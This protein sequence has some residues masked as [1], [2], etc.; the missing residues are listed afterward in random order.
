MKK[1]ILI[2]P[3]SF[4]RFM[5][6][7]GVI[8]NQYD[9]EI[10]LN[11][12]GKT[13]TEEQMTELCSDIDKIIV[14]ID[15]LGEKVLRRAGKLKAISKYGAGLDNIDLQVA[16]ELKIKVAKAAGANAT[17]VAELGVGLFFALARKIADAVAEVK[18]GAWNR[19]TL[20]V[21]LT[22]KTAGIVG[23]GFIGRET[24]RLCRGLGMGVLVY[25]PF[26]EETIVKRYNGDKVKLED[27]LQQ[28][29]FISLH[30]PL[31][32]ET[33]N[34]INKETL[35]K[36]KETAYLINTARGSLVNEDDLYEA[37]KEGKIRGAAQDV[38]SKEP[39]GEHKLLTLNNFLLTPHMG[40]YTR[41]AIEKM[42]VKSTQN[43][44]DMLY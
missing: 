11:R 4:S 9:L 36:M 26:V 28:S 30:L 6:Q 15:P 31:T 42:V 34:I 27:M 21:E 29:D 16:K 7:A 3:R 35:N 14:G 12:T 13:Y 1:K 40:A 10:I 39:P 33:K 2:T 17:A 18:K 32:A 20:G 25:D 38:F 24:A 23:F 43:L 22:G 37:L 44:V 41:E 8:L 19:G 5:E